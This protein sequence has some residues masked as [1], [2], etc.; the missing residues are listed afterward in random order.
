MVTVTDVVQP[1][2]SV[3]V[4]TYEPAVKPVAVVVDWDGVVFHEYVYGVV[5]PEAVTVALPLFPPLQSMFT[6]VVVAVSAVG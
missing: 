5:P 2:A 6:C 3:T 1:F 4:I